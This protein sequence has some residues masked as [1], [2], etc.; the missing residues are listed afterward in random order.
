VARLNVL[1]REFLKS[2][3]VLKVLTSLAGQPSPSSPEEMRD[4]VQREM[5]RWA[6]VIESRGIERQ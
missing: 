5:A 2:P 6:K 1:V 4:L 3:D